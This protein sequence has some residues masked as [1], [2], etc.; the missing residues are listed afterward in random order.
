[1]NVGKYPVIDQGGVEEVSCLPRCAIQAAN[2]AC[3]KQGPSSL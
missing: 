2:H 1:M 3:I